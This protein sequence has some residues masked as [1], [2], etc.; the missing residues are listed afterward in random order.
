MADNYSLKHLASRDDS[1]H[2]E[3]AIEIALKSTLGRQYVWVVVEAEEDCSFYNQFFNS[4]A[5]VYSASARNKNGGYLVVEKFVREIPNTC[6][7]VKIL[8]IRDADYTRYQAIPYS[9]P[10][11][12]FLT[13]HRDL[14]MMMMS[15]V[16]VKQGLDA[17]NENFA[18]R[19]RNTIPFARTMGYLRIYNQE[20]SL[21]CCFSEA[22]VSL[23]SEWSEK[24]HGMNESWDVSLFRKFE[25]GVKK[26][27]ETYTFDEDEFKKFVSENKLE[28]ELVYDVCRGHDFL[29]LLSLMMIQTQLYNSKTITN[30]MIESSS[31]DDFKS[32]T[33]YNDITLWEREAGMSVLKS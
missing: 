17:W 32:T 29:S 23:K 24:K 1:L 3:N 7:S 26:S 18:E 6:S 19:I 12:V 4:N 13:Q 31:L 16:S 21:S 2:I 28:T 14:E 20:K 33:L 30:K 11:N 25:N 8:G 27:C 22:K 15:F 9:R 10:Q 5:K